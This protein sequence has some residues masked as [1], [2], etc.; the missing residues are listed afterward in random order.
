MAL[1]QVLYRWGMYLEFTAEEVV[2]PLTPALQ[3]EGI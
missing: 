2:Q 3:T 1:P